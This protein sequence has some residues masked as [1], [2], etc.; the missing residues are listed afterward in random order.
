MKNPYPPTHP[1][2][3]FQQ[4]ITDRITHRMLSMRPDGV[5]VILYFAAE[6]NVLRGRIATEREM[7]TMT[8]GVKEARPATKTKA[9]RKRRRRTRT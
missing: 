1:A 3:K 7:E 9:V 8:P 5:G 6:G 4:W 2:H